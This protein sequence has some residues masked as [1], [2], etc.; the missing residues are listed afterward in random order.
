[1]ACPFAIAFDF[2]ALGGSVLLMVRE[3]RANELN[4]DMFKFPL[5][6]GGL[7]TTAFGLY[8]LSKRTTMPA[9]APYRFKMAGRCFALSTYCLLGYQWYTTGKL[10]PSLSLPPPSSPAVARA[11]SEA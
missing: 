6:I 4:A 10:R 2:S 3:G 8:Q 9:P 11:D 7:G 5:A 1:M